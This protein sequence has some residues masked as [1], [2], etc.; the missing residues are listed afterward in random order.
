MLASHSGL[1]VKCRRG[2]LV[3]MAPLSSTALASSGDVWTSCTIVWTR[4]SG[5]VPDCDCGRRV[6]VQV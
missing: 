4:G 2:A 5:L 3:I 6:H 1:I